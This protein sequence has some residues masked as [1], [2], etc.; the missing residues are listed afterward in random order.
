[1]KR[2]IKPLLLNIILSSLFGLTNSLYQGSFIY[3]FIISFLILYIVYYIASII[4]VGTFK[5]KTKQL[6]L[7]KLENLSTILDCSY[8]SH[9][10]IMTFIP[11]QNEKTNFTCSSC[12][13]ENSV[14]I[15]F[16]VARITESLP[17]NS[18][19]VNENK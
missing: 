7:S 4:I 12:N 13:K 15:Q 14:I 5:E 6:E 18:L 1:M 16:I 8:C 10:N 19:L 9:K 3:A 11:D 17:I 2:I